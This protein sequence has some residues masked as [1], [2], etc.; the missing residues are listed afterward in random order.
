MTGFHPFNRLDW[1]CDEILAELHLFRDIEGVY[2]DYIIKELVECRRDD[3]GWMFFSEMCR[4]LA[5]KE[6]I[7]KLLDQKRIQVVPG[8][9][10]A[11][12]RR[13]FRLM[14]V[15]DAIVES[16]DESERPIGYTRAWT[17]RVSSLIQKL[18]SPTTGLG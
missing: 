15:L 16:L 7:K 1:I 10:T 8:K 13:M 18:A 14:N 17:S 4:A 12:G 2:E 6:A 5:V 11:T 3:K 9:T